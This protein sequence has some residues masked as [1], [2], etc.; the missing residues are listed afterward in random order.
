MHLQQLSKARNFSG[1]TNTGIVVRALRMHVRDFFVLPC[2]G[3]HHNI[4]RSLSKVS[5]KNVYKISYFHKLLANWN[6][7]QGL[8]QEAEEKSDD[9]PQYFR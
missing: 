8:T 9:E 7:P 2:V 6:R 4:G 1:R 5:Y 3:R